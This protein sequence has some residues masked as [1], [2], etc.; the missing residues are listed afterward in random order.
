MLAQGLSDIVAA[1]DGK[2]DAIQSVFQKYLD[3]VLPFT[4]T[5]T[6]SK[7]EE[8]K[9][10]MEKEVNKGMLTFEPLPNLLAKKAKTMAVPDEWASAMRA[11]VAKKGLT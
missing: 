7:D 4:K 8:M 11:R 3:A 10:V 5:Q 1:S 2:T 6:S 9:K